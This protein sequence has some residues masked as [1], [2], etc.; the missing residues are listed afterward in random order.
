LFVE[1]SVVQENNENDQQPSE[2]QAEVEPAPEDQAEKL[3]EKQGENVGSP[4]I[5]NSQ[6]NEKKEEIQPL[7]TVAQISEMK[8]DKDTPPALSSEN[9]QD[10]KN[11]DESI[12]KLMNLKEKQKS[13]DDSLERL[14]KGEEM[15]PESKS[16]NDSPRKEQIEEIKEKEIQNKVQNPISQPS[17]SKR[18][19]RE[20]K[21]RAIRNTDLNSKCHVCGK[22]S[23][24]APLIPCTQ[25]SENCDVYF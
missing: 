9:F 7:S 17:A 6:E 10:G 21:P 3:S 22:G 23:T 24:R 15:I 25:G 4:K 14:Q 18:L 1:S 20:R 16:A 19:L 8:A 2:K 12:P 5:Q 13:L 11:L